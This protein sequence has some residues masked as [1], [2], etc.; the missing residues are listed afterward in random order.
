MN[1]D[2]AEQPPAVHAAPMRRA[3]SRGASLGQLL[4]RRS[5]PAGM[6]DPRQRAKWMSRR[7]EIR[8]K[9]HERSEETATRQSDDA[10]PCEP[11]VAE[12]Q[13]RAAA[14]IGLG[15]EGAPATVP[16][17]T[18]AAATTEAESAVAEEMS[19]ARGEGSTG[20]LSKYGEMEQ[21]G[22]VNAVNDIMNLRVDKLAMAVHKRMKQ[23]P[24]VAAVTVPTSTC[25]AA[26]EVGTA[27][28][29][30]KG[31]AGSDVS[32][33]D[34]SPHRELE[35]NGFVN[36]VND[37]MNLRVDKL[38]RAV[39]KRVT[40]SRPDPNGKNAIGPGGPRRTFSESL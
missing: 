7:R 15:Q 29:E 33:V 10:R 30:D 19:T 13:A 4:R 28:A 40:K 35:Q 22:F 6:N 27:V 38:A 1:G 17:L 5:R 8:E 3:L 26:T 11:A 36:A 9:R 25:S 34:P 21:N 37:V 24:T 39:H 32:V 23:R 16:S 31:I 14:A 18:G 12:L 2:S 20:D